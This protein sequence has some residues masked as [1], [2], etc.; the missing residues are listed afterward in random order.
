M[1]IVFVSNQWSHLIFNK[2]HWTWDTLML[3][4]WN[5]RT[6]EVTAELISFIERHPELHE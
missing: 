6:D 2:L 4:H 1:G 5:N 3:E